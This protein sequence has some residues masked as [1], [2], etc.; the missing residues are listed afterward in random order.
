L[1][2]VQLKTLSLLKVGRKRDRCF[3]DRNLAYE[4]GGA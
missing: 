2:K 4:F 1:E 3:S